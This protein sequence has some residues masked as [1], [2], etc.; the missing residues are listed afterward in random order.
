MPKDTPNTEQT[1]RDKFLDVINHIDNPYSHFGLGVEHEGYSKVSAADAIFELCQQAAERA[2]LAGRIGSMQLYMDTCEEQGV[3][4][5]WPTLHE[6][7]DGQRLALA[8]LQ[9]EKENSCEP[10][11]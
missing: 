9:K 3:D 11:S 6:F 1:L 4:P 5:S 2:E 7:Q 8:E 10:R